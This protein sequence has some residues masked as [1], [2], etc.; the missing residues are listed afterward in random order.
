MTLVGLAAASQ[1]TFANAINESREY[2]ANKVVENRAERV[3]KNIV[4]E[5]TEW[6]F[7][8]F[9]DEVSRC[10]MKNTPDSPTESQD[11]CEKAFFKKYWVK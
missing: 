10:A 1:L 8:L 6:R 4:P 3:D 9:M 5:T 7:R 2:F 11:V